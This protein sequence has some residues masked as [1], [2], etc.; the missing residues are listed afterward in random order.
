MTD[1]SHEQYDWR[2]R[3]SRINMTGGGL[4]KYDWRRRLGGGGADDYLQ[5]H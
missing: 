4:T 1:S 2:R 5:F 3:L